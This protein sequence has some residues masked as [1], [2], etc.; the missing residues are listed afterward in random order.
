M[1]TL[2]A[3]HRGVA[4]SLHPRTLPWTCLVSGPRVRDVRPHLCYQNEAKCPEEG[5]ASRAGSPAGGP[6]GHRLRHTGTPRGRQPGCCPQRGRWGGDELPSQV[7]RRA[8]HSP[9]GLQGWNQCTYF[10]APPSFPRP[11]TPLVSS[12]SHPKPHVRKPEH[13]RC[14]G[15]NK[16][17]GACPRFKLHP[18]LPPRGRGSP[19]SG[20]RPVSS[21]GHSLPPI[22][23]PRLGG[24]NRVGGFIR[25][26]DSHEST[27]RGRSLWWYRFSRQSPSGLLGAEAPN[28]ARR[29]GLPPVGVGL[30]G[31]SV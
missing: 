11:P 21:T 3:G 20:R 18:L 19:N 12:L 6:T 26:V 9:R 16:E 13:R 24:Q 17:D 5:C 28:H 25:A 30:L 27:E 10:K 15:E 2:P 23:L 22:S 31:P 4:C 8:T 14:R 1:T 29:P 7:T